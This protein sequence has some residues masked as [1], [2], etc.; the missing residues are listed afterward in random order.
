[1]VACQEPEACLREADVICTC[2][3][4]DNELIRPEWFKPGACGVGIEG[5]CAHTIPTSRRHRRCILP[6]A[7]SYPASRRHDSG[8]RIVAITIGMAICDIGQAGTSWALHQAQ[9]P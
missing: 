2:T 7:T 5:V 3:N 9:S 6:S 1:M 8:E 4:G